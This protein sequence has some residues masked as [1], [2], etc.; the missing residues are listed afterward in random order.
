MKYFFVGRWKNGSPE[1][2]SQ[3]SGRMPTGIRSDSQP[4][5]VGTLPESEST[6]AEPRHEWCGSCCWRKLYPKQQLLRKHDAIRQQQSAE[7]EERH[8]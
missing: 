7:A 8:L 2:E 3:I 4:I 1:F 5:T 6:D